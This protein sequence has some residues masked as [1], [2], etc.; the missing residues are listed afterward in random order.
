MRLDKNIKN[1]TGV[2]DGVP[3]LEFRSADQ[4]DNFITVPL[5]G[6]RGAVSIND[7]GI[8]CAKFGGPFP[9]GFVVHDDAVRHWVPDS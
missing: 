5:V 2:V 1:V 4:N 3:Q 6:W 9:D 8:L 7:S